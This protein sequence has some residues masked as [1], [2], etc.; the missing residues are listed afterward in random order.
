MRRSLGRMQ[1]V[2]GCVG[3]KSFATANRILW[4]HILIQWT[5]KAPSAIGCAVPAFLI[6]QNAAWG[7]GRH[8]GASPAVTCKRNFVTIGA[9]SV[10]ANAIY[11]AQTLLRVTS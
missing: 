3:H 8:Y 1:R 10:A 6:R 5:S 7:I 2:A 4:L 11:V 9:I